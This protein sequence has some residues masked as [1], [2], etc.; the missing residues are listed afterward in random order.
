MKS[1]LCFPDFS[2]PSPL[3]KSGIFFNMQQQKIWI[4]GLKIPPPRIWKNLDLNV[5]IFQ[6]ESVP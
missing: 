1:G 5:F 2:D 4:T 6:F 3:L